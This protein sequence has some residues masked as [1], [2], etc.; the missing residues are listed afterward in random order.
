VA[1]L[2]LLLLTPLLYLAVMP[3]LLHLNS[4]SPWHERTVDHLSALSI[5]AIAVKQVASFCFALLGAR[6]LLKLP[7]VRRL[8]GLTTPPSF[9]FN[10][11][12]LAATLALLMA[13]SVTMVALDTLLIGGSD[14]TAVL[15]SPYELVGLVFVAL[16][17]LAG[18]LLCCRFIEQQ[19]ATTDHLRHVES[20]LR[21]SEERFELAMQA[22]NDGLI[23]WAPQQQR[24]YL[25]PRWRSVL[26]YRDSEI[27]LRPVQWASLL[28]PDDRQPAMTTLQRA[29]DGDE[30]R[31]EIE[32]RA[33][34]FDGGY[35]HIK[36]RAMILRDA[37]QR[38]SRV[39]GTQR[40][41]T[42]AVEAARRQKQAEA[43]FNTTLEGVVVADEGGLIVAANP[44]L[45]SLS[46]YSE[47]QLLGQ[48]LAF[49]SADGGTSLGTETIP[50]DSDHWKGSVWIRQQSGEILPQWLTLSVVRD[51]HGKPIN[52]VGIYTDISA[53]RKNAAQMEFLAHHDPLTNLPN[54][55]LLKSRLIHALDMVKRRHGRGAVLF[56]DLDHFKQVNDSLGHR[57]GDELLQQLVQRLR[58]RLRESDTLAR[59][60][61]DEF[62]AILEDVTGPNDAAVVAA[63]LIEQAGLPFQ[64]SGGHEVQ[65]GCSVGIS[66]FP[67]DSQ[68]S[69]ELLH[70]ADLAL[71]QAK[72]A[73]RSRYNFYNREDATNS[74]R[75]L[76]S[77]Q[78]LN[79]ALTSGGLMLYFQPV[80]S[81][82]DGRVQ[83]SEALLRWREPD[84]RLLTP[85]KFMPMA[86]NTALM[87]RLGDW[88]LR[89]A[90]RTMRSW[91]DDGLDVT[92]M[93]VN[94]SLHQFK[95]PDLPQRIDVAL[96][97]S[98][99]EPHR[100]ELDITEA[101]MMPGGDDPLAR[102]RDLKSLG[103]T[104]ALDDFG[105]GY[106]CFAKLGQYPV[107]KI[108]VDT[109]FVHE[110][111][112]S[113]GGTAAAI[114]AMAKLLQIP[115]QAEGIETERQRELLLRSQ[116]VAGQGYL[117][118]HPM[119]EDDFR[120]WCGNNRIH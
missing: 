21:F 6:C 18:S 49:L 29:L 76:D 110:I 71:Y 5:L 25:S 109:R 77:N 28:H 108:K 113:F 112:E 13:L 104:L 46:G 22:A 60:G 3:A 107:D 119:P 31:V 65:V 23:D 36:A 103:L 42:E 68:D 47:T 43:V 20:E 81:L 48:P 44:A 87:A 67:E 2:P 56:L 83:G 19:I 37:Q 12:I 59:L 16:L 32:F 40:D 89:E 90:C 69:D 86:E 94:L 92:S 15:Q 93:T 91:I 80:V 30:T 26:G 120:A 53:L 98:G 62:V 70:N 45:T 57:Y 66:L 102:L 88:V 34:H 78:A 61:G 100:L 4:L 24:L 58:N 73:G 63:N 1:P 35:R 105:T 38:P 64:L 10:G 72:E 111:D 82:V 7:A 96:T 85:D 50:S 11:T 84:G 51:N 117:F 8:V 101:A 106:S 114:V 115:V 55:L 75:R 27:P 41:V 54:R 9:R 17:L 118:S 14:L 52:Y 116:C 99:L 95:M 33:L 79:V 74:Q 39:I 97:E